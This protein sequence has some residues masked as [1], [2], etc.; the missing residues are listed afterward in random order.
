M[1]SN[2]ARTVTQVDRSGIRTV[3]P[4]DVLFAGQPV[5]RR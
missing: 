4:A 5:T 3:A 2:D 1:T